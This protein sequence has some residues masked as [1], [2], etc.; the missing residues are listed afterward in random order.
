MKLD[1]TNF[2]SLDQRTTYVLKLIFERWTG[3]E[4]G[5]FYSSDLSSWSDSVQIGNLSFGK[6]M[7][8]SSERRK[9]TEHLISSLFSASSSTGVRGL[10][11]KKLSEVCEDTAALDRDA[12]TVIF[13]LISGEDEI[14]NVKRDKHNRFP[15]DASLLFRNGILDLPVVDLLAEYLQNKVMADIPRLELNSPAD[16][17]RVSHDVDVPFKLAFKSL[18][19]VPRVIAGDAYRRRNF[20]SIWRTPLDWMA[21]KSGRLERDPFNCFHRLLEGHDRAGRR[22]DFFFIAGHTGGRIDGDYT[23]NDT[24]V[25]TL[26]KEISCRGHQVGLHPSYF[27]SVDQKV[28]TSEKDELERT[29]HNLGIGIPLDSVRTHY[30]R[31]DPA[32]TPM[33]LKNCGFSTDSS[34]AFADFA[35]FRRGTCRSFPLWDWQSDEEIGLIENPLIAMEVSLLASHY[36]GLNHEEAASRIDT[37][38]E[39]CQRHR[40]TFSLLWHNNNFNSEKDFELYEYA[41]R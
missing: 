23:L 11:G 12:L 22:A 21:V 31:F 10:N 14:S 5:N 1:I 34:L 13:F 3:W 40:G 30:L 32:V 27:A 38:R 16:R 8:D 19:D 35:G 41:A 33:V 2:D 6:V 26:L 7:I 28:L 4:L 39:E 15:S 18:I 25:R 36:E 37:L 29:M 24:P 9:V 20:S 17:I